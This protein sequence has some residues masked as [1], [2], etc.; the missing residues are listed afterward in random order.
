M[1]GQDQSPYLG[2]GEFRR[3]NPMSLMMAPYNRIIVLHLTII[4]GGGL[5]M[6]M[7]SPVWLLA[8]L[9]GLKILMDVRAHLKERHSFGAKGYKSD[10]DPNKDTAT[11][12]NLA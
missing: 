2:S 5:T 12:S 3:T 4:A 6:V 7:G 11:I 1:F 9:I 10:T 8:L